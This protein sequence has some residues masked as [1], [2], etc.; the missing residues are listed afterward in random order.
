MDL[1]LGIV[2]G[3]CDTYSVLGTRTCSVCGSDLAMQPRSASGSPTAL[4]AR[5]GLTEPPSSFAQDPPVRRRSAGNQPTAGVSAIRSPGGD[6]AVA[7]SGAFDS[8]GSSSTQRAAA[9][10]AD[11][12]PSVEELMEQAKN[13]VC[14]NC[15]AG[16]PL[17]HKFC[18][19]CGT[20]VPPDILA[21]RTQFFGT[22]QTPG[23]AKLILIRG[24][25]SE[26]LSYQLNA[27]Q[28]LLG[29]TGQIVFGDDPFISSRHANLFYRNEKLVVRDEGSLNGV[30]FRVRGTVEVESG[31]EF[32][33]GE[34]L[35]RI[36]ATG[37]PD[38]GPDATRQRRPAGRC[39]RTHRLR[40]PALRARPDGVA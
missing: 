2:C 37:K 9:P 39:P 14:R 35:F 17:S 36:E 5:A 3:R 7:T 25:G 29:R 33:A 10:A 21:A 31:D 26:G 4:R 8:R 24:E 16:V 6:S 19:R 13:F 22:L 20:A 18:G 34:Q 38:D 15:G 28:H 40:E 23:K 30:F 12:E 27:E 32:L 11:E 1:E